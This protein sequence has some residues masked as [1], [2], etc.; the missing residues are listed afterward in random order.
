MIQLTDGTDQVDAPVSI[1]IVEDQDMVAEAFRRVIDREDDFSVVGVVGS[2]HDAIQSAR[3]LHPRVV[4]MDY[5]LPDG[6]GAEATKQIKAEQ[7]DIEVVMLTGLSSGVVLAEALEAGSSG[8]VPKEAHFGELIATIRTVIAGQVQVPQDLMTALVAHLRPHP[9]VF[10]SDLTPREAEVLHCLATGQSTTEIATQLFV[11]IHTVRNHI[12]NIL[13]KLQANSRLEAVAVAVQHG[14]VEMRADLGSLGMTRLADSTLLGLLDAMP[15][16]M[17]AVNEAGLIVLVN[18]QAERLFG[19]GREDLIGRPVELLVPIADPNLPPYGTGL[20]MAGRRKDGSEFPASVSVSTM[21]ADT[22]LLISATIRDATEVSEIEA[23]RVRVKTEAERVRLEAETERVKAEG[24]KTEAERVRLEAETERVKAEGEKTEAERVRL[25]AETDRVRLEIVV[26]LERLEVLGELK[27]L[28]A[29][30]ERVTDEGEKTEAERGRLE[31]EVERK[32]LEGKLHQLQRMESLGQLAGG[33][34]H[35]FNNLLAV[36]SNCASF[37]SEELD[38]KEAAQNDLGQIRV[39]AERAAQ[40]TRQLLAFAG[41]K[42][43]QPEVFDVNQVIATVGQLLHRTIGEH[44]ELAISLSTDPWLVE[45]DPGQL[46]QVLVNLAVNARD[47]MPDGGLLTIDAENIEIDEVYTETHPGLSPGR[48]VRVRVS[49]TGSGMEQAVLDHVFEPFF[50]TKPH[51]GTGLGLPTVFG[52]VAQAGGEIQLYSEPG[53]GTTCRVLLPAT[54]R[55]PAIGPSPTEGRDLHGTETVLV[56]EDEDDLRDVVRRILSRNGYVVLTCANGPE[57]IALVESHTGVIDLLLTDVI[58]PQMLGKEVATRIQEFRPGL[59]VLYMSG[60]ARPVL[61]PTLGEE[62][63][64]LEK[65]F[66][67]QLLLIK[68]RDVLD[69]VR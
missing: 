44:V 46:E 64:L 55:T 35:D 5:G 40:L 43:L 1:L 63:A 17:L 61:G 13:G 53:I 69:N 57:A 12:A 58:M 25:E 32:R 67:E 59:P 8:F 42:V 41:Q 14:L 19:Y 34:A 21:A 20:Q 36:I 3:A 10:G 9:S 49:D 54:D 48:Y 31:A 2:V 56:V 6:T 51:G 62:I 38:D 33:V 23:E 45:A 16:A 7:P 28:E 24:E 30:V 47:A 65:P 68:V 39:A 22:G 26:E 11:S 15:D 60:Y 37:V 52:I 50:T 18:A 27:R 29:E 66:S 4:I